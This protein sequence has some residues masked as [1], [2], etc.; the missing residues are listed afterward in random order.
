MRRILLLLAVVPLVLMTMATA[1]WAQPR[2]GP[3]MPGDFGLTFDTCGFPVTME[4]QGK[5]LHS[6]WTDAQGVY[7]SKDIFPGAHAVYTNDNT[8]AS[9]RV[10][11][12][13]QITFTIWPNGDWAFSLRGPSGWGSNP[14]TGEPGVWLST[15]R[16]DYWGTNFGTEDQ[17]VN[18]RVRGRTVDLCPL[19]AP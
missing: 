2:Q 13:G 4:N 19:I 7:H 17:T 5:A 10:P 14:A 6:E 11:N 1:T 16:V 15:G 18:I 9:V 3:P 12:N 8:G